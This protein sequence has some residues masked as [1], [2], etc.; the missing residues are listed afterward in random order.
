M[1]KRHLLGRE[2]WL[3][4]LLR[5]LRLLWKERN[6]NTLQIHRN[7]KLVSCVDPKIPTQV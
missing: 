2:G 1:V 3:I 7:P 6:M 5:L 4:E